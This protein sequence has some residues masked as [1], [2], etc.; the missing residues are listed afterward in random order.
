MSTRAKSILFAVAVIF[1]LFAAAFLL[2]RKSTN[3]PK[4]QSSAT[5]EKSTTESTKH[6]KIHLVADSTPENS[7]NPENSYQLKG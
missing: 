3:Y 5:A 2:G 1:V 7:P 6:K 4:A